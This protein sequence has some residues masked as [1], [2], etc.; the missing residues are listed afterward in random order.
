MNRPA[1]DGAA[2]T[3]RDDHYEELRPG[4]YHLPATI[5]ES[6]PET[7][8]G[9]LKRPRNELTLATNSQALKVA[10]GAFSI[11]HKLL[12]TTLTLVLTFAAI[13]GISTQSASADEPANFALFDANASGE[14]IGWKNAYL[15]SLLDYY[16][17]D[18][19]IPGATDENFAAKFEEFFA[20][21]GLSNFT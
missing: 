17:Y 5:A 4:H 7:G 3:K 10:A 13:V 8:D 19:V 12:L 1:F 15:L 2:A 18:G 21:L 9:R 14:G 11:S 16:V 20:P 6:D